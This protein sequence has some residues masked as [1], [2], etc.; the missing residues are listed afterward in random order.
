M[1]VLI[2]GSTG[3][4]GKSVLYECINDYRIKKIYLINRSSIN[5]VNKKVEEFIEVDFLKIKQFKNKRK[6]SYMKNI[7]FNF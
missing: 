3:M 7:E 5:M 2:T 6:P 4:V 1:N